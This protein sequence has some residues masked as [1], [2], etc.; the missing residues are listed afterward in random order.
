MP[1][2]YPEEIGRYVGRYAKHGQGEAQ[3]QRLLLRLEADLKRECNLD[4][5]MIDRIMKVLGLK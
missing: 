1:V 4:S 2:E 3:F 5:E